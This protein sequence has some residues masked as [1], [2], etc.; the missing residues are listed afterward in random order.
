MEKIQK[1]KVVFRVE[2]SVY[3]NSDEDLAAMVQQ[4]SFRLRM[5]KESVAY[6]PGGIL[7]LAQPVSVRKLAK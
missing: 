1:R 3:Y 7:A 4:L 6:G 2:F 5:I